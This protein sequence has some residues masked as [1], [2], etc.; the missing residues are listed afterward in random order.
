MTKKIDI[1]EDI[2]N[3]N[4]RK[5][6]ENRNG[7]DEANTFTLNFMAS[8]GAGKTSLIMATI[9]KLK[10][11][12]SIAYIDGDIATSIDVDKVSALGIPSIQINTGGQCHLDAPMIHQAISDLDLGQIDLVII[13]NV[14]NLVC[15]TSFK[16]GAHRNILIAS[17]PE[18]DDKPYKYPGMY[19][20]VDAMALNKMDVIEYFDFDMDY[21]RKGVEILNPGLYFFPV[22]CKTNYGVNEWSE[23]VSKEITD[24]RTAAFKDYILR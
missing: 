21:F 24:F 1:V 10:N 22:S 6:L 4:D 2:L 13:E 5:A 3:L 19:Q 17:V 23:W 9:E 18:G 15:P 7:F 12:Y 8:P 20:G 14:G 16:L 11:E